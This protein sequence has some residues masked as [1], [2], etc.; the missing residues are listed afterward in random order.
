VE[1]LVAHVLPTALMTQS[2]LLALAGAS[3]L[4]VH[5]RIVEGK[6][7]MTWL[8]LAALPA[9]SLASH[10]MVTCIQIPHKP[11]TVWQQL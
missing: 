7:V 9:T 5:G 4:P 10:V 8:A 3:G 2:Y 11:C 1:Q 6:T